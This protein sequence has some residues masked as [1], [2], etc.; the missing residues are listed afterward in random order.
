MKKYLRALT[1]LGCCQVASVLLSFSSESLAESICDKEI[2]PLFTDQYSSISNPQYRV[3]DN[4]SDWCR[5]WNT[6]FGS[7]SPKPACNTTLV[8][9][10]REV[11]ILAATGLHS[12]GGF[13]VQI[14][15]IGSGGSSGNIHVLVTVSSPAAGCPVTGIPT[16]PATV[17][18]VHRP[19]RKAIFKFETVVM[20]CSP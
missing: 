13:P 8:D 5:V 19:V 16:T 17:V 18:K 6:W 14:T 15:C 3:I 2:T 4:L 10:S 12:S 20:D 7:L 1:F 11:A 9:F